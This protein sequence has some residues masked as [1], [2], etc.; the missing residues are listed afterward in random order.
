MAKWIDIGSIN[1]IP[2]G[3]K[4]IAHAGQHELVLCRPAAG[5]VGGGEGDIQAVVNICPHAGMPIG[6]GELQGC[7]L[8]CPYHGYAYHVATGRNIDYPDDPP[9]QRLPVRIT[10]GRIE[11]DAEGEI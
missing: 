1:D 9:L 10:D 4:T 11:V 5:S 8:T 2:E 6:D 7:V 3:G